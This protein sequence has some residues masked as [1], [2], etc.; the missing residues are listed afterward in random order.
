MRHTQCDTTYILV[1][2][3]DIFLTSSSNS[4]LSYLKQQLHKE[5]SLKDLV[6]LN[7]FL[8]LKVNVFE[9]FNPLILTKKHYW[10]TYK[11]RYG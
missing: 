10:L 3:D 1:Y 7:Y 11:G 6:D 2:V 5:F 9:W 8:D 4:S